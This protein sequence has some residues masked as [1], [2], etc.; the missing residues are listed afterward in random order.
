[1]D[2]EAEESPV[3]C[4]RLLYLPYLMG[5]RTPHLDPDCRGAFIG[6]SAMHTRKDMIRAVMEGVVYSLRDCE[7][8][9]KDMGV[10]FESM[11]AC[12]GGGTSPLWR[13]MLA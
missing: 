10:A 5:E 13:S 3:G 11:A 6:L 8:V 9:L 4:N 7:E 1:M 12:G 2:K